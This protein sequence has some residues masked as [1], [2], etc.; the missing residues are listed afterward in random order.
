[1]RLLTVWGKVSGVS[2]LLFLAGCSSS[3]D[4]GHV[5]AASDETASMTAE[6]P[7]LDT[8]T[9]SMIKDHIKRRAEELINT[10][11]RVGAIN[12]ELLY[13]ADISFNYISQPTALGNGDSSCSAEVMVLY[14]GNQNSEAEV[15][16]TYAKLAKTN[17]EYNSNPFANMATGYNLKQEL[18]SLGVDEFTIN[19]FSGI[20]RNSFAIKM[21]YEVKATQSEDGQRQRSYVAGI[22]KPA[23]MLA[24]VAVLDNF[25]QKN[26]KPS[27]SVD[28]S[29]ND[30]A[31][32]MASDDDYIDD[33]EPDI[34]TRI[35]R[36][37]TAPA[38]S[39]KASKK[40]IENVEYIDEPTISPEE[41]DA[42]FVEADMVVVEEPAQ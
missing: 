29:L 25:M 7:C 42:A 26:K 18:A 40:S 1:M 32:K 38:P 35:V 10:K 12:P 9:I 22:G 34:D 16:A 24:T 30:R 36:N 15:V 21:D 28:Q 2:L 3:V 4:D 14:Q 31:I 8:Q 33:F 13:S 6:N 17:I 11:Y 41:L 23:A 5:G 19:E 37:K 27:K 20:S 39:L